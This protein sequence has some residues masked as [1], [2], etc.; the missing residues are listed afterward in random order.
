MREELLDNAP[1]LEIM[2]RS[3]I[4]YEDPDLEQ[5]DRVIASVSLRNSVYAEEILD[6][7]PDN[8]YSA[9]V[10][11][12]LTPFIANI[13]DRKFLHNRDYINVLLDYRLYLTQPAAIEPE[14]RELQEV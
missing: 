14:V 1:A 3:G 13:D 8:P 10:V 12:E 2:D 11:T 5:L 6:H 9:T 4:V 7:L